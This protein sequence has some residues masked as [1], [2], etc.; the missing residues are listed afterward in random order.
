MHA[1]FEDEV[2]AALAALS[3][4]AAQAAIVLTSVQQ[5]SIPEAAGI[6]GC[7]TAT[8][9]WRIHEARRLLKRRLERYLSP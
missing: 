8:M 1:E 3:P 9:Y 5:I 7:S 2:S 6:E 4:E